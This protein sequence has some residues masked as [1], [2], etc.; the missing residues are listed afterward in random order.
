MFKSW[1]ISAAGSASHWQCGGQGF[2]SPMLHQDNVTIN[3]HFLDLRK[4]LFILTE[5]VY[6]TMRVLFRK[7]QGTF[8]YWRVP[9]SYPVICIFCC[10]SC[11]SGRFLC[12]ISSQKIVKGY[13]MTEVGSATAMCLQNA[14]KDAW[15]VAFIELHEDT[16][17]PDTDMGKSTS[18]QLK[19]SLQK[20]NDMGIPLLQK[21]Y[22]NHF[23]GPVF[24][25][26]F[27][28]FKYPS[29]Y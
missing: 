19:N 8:R 11:S 5:C 7:N 27:F 1:G 29:A 22:P 13:G 3:R 16:Q 14:N 18:G 10:S 21:L 15:P 6:G 20:E 24:L 26:R 4:C 2:E 23:S 25:D 17:D 28:A 9:F 12:V